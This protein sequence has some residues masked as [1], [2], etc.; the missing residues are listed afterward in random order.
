MYPNQ[1]L[2]PKLLQRTSNKSRLVLAMGGSRL[3]QGKSE[4]CALR[5]P[6]SARLRFSKEFPTGLWRWELPSRIWPRWLPHGGG[7]QNS[8]I[9]SYAMFS[10]GRNCKQIR[11]T[12][13]TTT[14]MSNCWRAQWRVGGTD[15]ATHQAIRHRHHKSYSQYGCARA[16]Q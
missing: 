15:G 9:S 14:R 5:R 1:K 3:R 2:N 11:T 16:I 7:R 6:D 13:A 8:F 4:C 12:I 10:P